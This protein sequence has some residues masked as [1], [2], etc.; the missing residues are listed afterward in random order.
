[1]IYSTQTVI[2]TVYLFLYF[3]VV[4]TLEFDQFIKDS[5]VC[6]GPLWDLKPGIE[7][8]DN[9]KV[10]INIFSISN[11]SMQRSDSVHY[12]KV[13]VSSKNNLDNLK[14]KTIM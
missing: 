14:N 12:S 8:E 6:G 3:I 13:G 11:V 9:F 1:M 5:G 10:P 2:L 7:K 4:E